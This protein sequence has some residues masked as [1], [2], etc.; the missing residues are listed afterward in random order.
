M[1]QRSCQINGLLTNCD[2]HH[3]AFHKNSRA[4]ARID[5]LKGAETPSVISDLLG[6][7]FAVA[8]EGEPF[9]DASQAKRTPALLPAVDRSRAARAT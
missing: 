8:T 5:L 3:K 1:I 6:T 7:L 2:L 4:A 9:F